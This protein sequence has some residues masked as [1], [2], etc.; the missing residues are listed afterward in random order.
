MAIPLAAQETAPDAPSRDPAALVADYDV[1]VS[2]AGTDRQMR[3]HIS[4][5]RERAVTPEGRRDLEES[6]LVGL[7]SMGLPPSFPISYGRAV[8]FSAAEQR[9]RFVAT[10]LLGD[11]DGDWQVTMAEVQTML[12]S[13]RG[14]NGA[15]A[16]FLRSDLDTDGIVTFEEIKA[17]AMATPSSQDGLPER[18]W[19]TLSIF[20]FDDDGVVTREEFDRGLDAVAASP[21]D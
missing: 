12:R 15:A 2:K 3:S 7:Q 1:I 16:A 9:S 5:M 21:R 20:D 18:Q 14:E 8:D 4:M 6:Y 11:V 10:I 17:Q 19:K 13:N